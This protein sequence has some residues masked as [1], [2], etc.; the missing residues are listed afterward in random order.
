MA[1]PERAPGLSE[2]L[3]HGGRE[4]CPQRGQGCS[5]EALGCW[6]SQRASGW[7]AWG[8]KRPQPGRG[9]EGRESSPGYRLSKGPVAGKSCECF[10]KRSS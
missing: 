8:K 5:G 6:N 1:E 7:L 2:L 9:C 10:G 4:M 3:V